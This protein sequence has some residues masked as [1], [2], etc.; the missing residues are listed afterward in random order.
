MN[1]CECPSGYWV[2]ARR[3]FPGMQPRSQGARRH[4][5]IA[6]KERLL[7]VPVAINNH[8]RKF[9]NAVLR[10][11]ADNT[12]IEVCLV[13]KSLHVSAVLGEEQFEDV[14]DQVPSNHEL[15]E[16][17]RVGLVILPRIT[18]DSNRC[19]VGVVRQALRHSE[20]LSIVERD[21]V[22]TY[23]ELASAVVDQAHYL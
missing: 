17:S 11:C 3:F 23:C 14:D 12:F 21:G 19:I 2:I 15:P 13:P 22:S 1:R 9:R 18:N 6:F 10:E 20:V 4:R 5:I 8:V 7:F 16:K